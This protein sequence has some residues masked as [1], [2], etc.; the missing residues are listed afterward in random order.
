MRLTELEAREIRASGSSQ[1]CRDDHAR[2][3]AHIHDPFIVNGEVDC[4]RVIEFLT[5]YNEFLKHPIKP[6]GHFVER[7]MKL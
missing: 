2:M 3:S 5:E 4:D 1:A 6:A 7:D